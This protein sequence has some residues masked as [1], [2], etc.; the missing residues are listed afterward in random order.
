MAIGLFLSLPRPPAVNLDL[1]REAEKSPDQYDPGKHQQAL[2][3]RLDG[4][5]VDDIGRDQKFQTE[6]DRTAEAGAKAGN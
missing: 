1:K 4:D 3:C 6:Q 5:R 2:N